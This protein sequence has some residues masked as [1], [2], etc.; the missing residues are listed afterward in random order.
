MITKY[1]YTTLSAIALISIVLFSV[2]LFINSSYIKFSLMAITLVFLIFGI[3]F[4]RDPERKIPEGKDL[5]LS[6]ADGKIISIMEIYDGEFLKENC[7]RISIFMSPLNVHVN[8]VPVTGIVE[9]LKYYPGK[10]LIAFEEKASEKNERMSI[11]ISSENGK[12]KFVQIAGF[13]ARRIV[14]DL[15]ENQKVR[16]GERFG[17]IKFGSRV[18]VYLPK[19]VNILVKSGEK[20]YAGETVLSKFE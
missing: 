19:N 5:I 4:F 12:I 15:E 1:G 13:I 8:R 7:Y 18:D 11:G 10:Y 17:M 6:P 14:C 3:V 9:F 20:V 2:S 16:A